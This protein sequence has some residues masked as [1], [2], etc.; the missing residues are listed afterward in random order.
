MARPCAVAHIPAQLEW[1]VHFP[2]QLNSLPPIM[3]HWIALSKCLFIWIALKMALTPS[4]LI[5]IHFIA[6]RSGSLL[7]LWMKA[8]QSKYTGGFYQ[9]DLRREVSIT[10]EDISLGEWEKN[11][12]AVVRSARI[13]VVG[14]ISFEDSQGV[15]YDETNREV[16]QGIL[17][18]SSRRKVLQS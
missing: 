15:H 14:L 17:S 6:S 11:C 12:L 10:K 1:T 3:S 4:F 18:V 13:G 2:A 5:C 16:R 7:L 8:T 9:G